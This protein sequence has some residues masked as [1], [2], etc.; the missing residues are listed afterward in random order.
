MLE[1]TEPILQA[2]VPAGSRFPQ[3]HTPHQ[4]SRCFGLMGP[5]LVE[6]L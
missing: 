4:Q 2:A 5:R 3:P 1:W 6:Q